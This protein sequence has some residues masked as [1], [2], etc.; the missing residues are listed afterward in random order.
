MAKRLA[1]EFVITSLQLT[2][3]EMSEFL[4]WL[5]REKL[6]A[7]IKVVQ[8]G[9]QEFVL[10]E[11]QDEEPFV[12]PLEF[13]QG[14]YW[15]AGRFR[16]TNLKLA[17][18]L[19]RAITRFKGDSRVFRIYPDV[20][21]VTRYMQGSVVRIVEQCGQSQTL[22]YASK[23]VPEELIRLEQLFNRRRAED[24]IQSARSEINRLLDRRLATKD[25]L[26][27]KPID[28]KLTDLNHH[29]FILEGW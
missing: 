14:R 13:D 29:L 3:A 4:R 21:V 25:P 1:T 8:N 2:E 17:N 9:N 10:E 26:E 27:L 7:S 5:S 12:L 6:S 20:V 18:L 16:I 15:I 11:G 19:C 24:E 22:V 28:R 23:R